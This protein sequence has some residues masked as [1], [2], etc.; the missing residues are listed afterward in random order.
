MAG[1][2]L[3]FTSNDNLAMLVGSLIDL[4]RTHAGAGLER[5]A[6]IARALIDVVLLVGDALEVLGPHGQG[7][8]TARLAREVMARVLDDEPEAVLVGELDGRLD[9]LDR[10]HGHGVGR[11]AA[12]R[13]VASVDAALVQTWRLARQSL[14][15]GAEHLNGIV[16]AGTSL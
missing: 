6:G 2:H 7:A 1:T 16:V 15:D 4:P 8:G 11:E 9:L 3:A 13:A 5:G 14:V 10:G 12:Q